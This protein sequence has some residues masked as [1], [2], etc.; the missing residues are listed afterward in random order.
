M[1]RFLSFGLCLL[2]A[3]S[4]YA[5]KVD[6]FIKEEMEKR[7]VPG[8]ALTVIQN[9]KR[10]KTGAYGYANLEHNVEVTRDTV[11]EIGS[12]TK[13]FT[14]AGIMLLVQDGKVSVDDKISKHL[15]NTPP[16]WKEITV[17][18]LLVHT[19]GIKSYTSIEKGFELTE[20]LTQEQ[21]IKLIGAYPLE[22]RPG[23]KY[24]YCNSAYNLLG[25]IIENGSGK[26][27]WQFLGERI[28]GPLGMTTTT[29]RDP[30]LI[31]SNRAQGY[32]KSRRSGNRVNRDY[33]VT[34]VFAAGAIVS[35]LSDMAKW[36]AALDGNEVLSA[37][38]K[39]QMWT[40]LKFNDGTSR[41]Y[42]FG[43]KLDASEGHKRIWHSGSTSGFTASFQRY[44]DDRLTVILFCNSGADSVASNLAEKVAH[45]YL[46]E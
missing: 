24:S 36:D 31:I 43:W 5:D 4:V 29:N 6:R 19:S 40:P 12:V 16:A 10:A 41:E 3:T 38:S 26:S 25:Y 17:R 2:V 44:P 35:T 42:G 1:K 37:A 20:H 30:D 23:E 18:H 45:L 8:V 34:D 28:F 33:D 13:Q 22:S 39:S 21:F 9:G 7:D 32:E 27:Y 15:K 14:A 11:F 46:N